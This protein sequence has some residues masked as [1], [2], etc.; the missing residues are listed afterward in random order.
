MKSPLNP[1]PVAIIAVF[2]VFI[3]GTAGLIVMACAHRTDLVSRDYYEQELRFQGQLERVERTRRLQPPVAVAYD[4]ARR[5]LRLSLPPDHAR[6]DARGR[7]RFYRAS[8][9]ALDREVNLALDADGRQAVDVADLR[10]GAWKVRVSWTVE[11]EEFSLDQN[12][13]IGS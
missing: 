1:W 4:P 7:I 2:A 11:G 5:Q 9:A 3:A 8:A 10:R 12:L 6:R 13:W